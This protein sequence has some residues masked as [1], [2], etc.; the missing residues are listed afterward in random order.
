MARGDV[1][2]AE[3]QPGVVAE[4]RSGTSGYAGIAAGGEAGC[5][6]RSAA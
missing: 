2:R 3:V 6:G 4:E 5:E 1:R